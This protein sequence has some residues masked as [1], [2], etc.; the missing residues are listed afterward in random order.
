MRGEGS[1]CRSVCGGGG[2]YL[3]DAVEVKEMSGPYMA[4]ST[5]HSSHHAGLLLPTGSGRLS[6]A[7]STPAGGRVQPSVAQLG[8]SSRQSQQPPPSCHPGCSLACNLL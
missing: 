3:A 7:G 5:W 1:E 2:A 8:C 4:S 6:P